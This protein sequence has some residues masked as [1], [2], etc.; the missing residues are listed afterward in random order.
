MVMPKRPVRVINP[1]AK[2]IAA[3]I[4]REVRARCGANATFEQRQD[5]AAMVTQE[6]P[7]RGK[8][9]LREALAEKDVQ[10][11]QTNV[12]VREREVAQM[13]R[14]AYAELFVARKAIDIH[15][16]SAG[17]LRQIAEHEGVT[18]GAA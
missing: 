5:V 9:Q 3:L 4:A 11:A 1:A 13:V 16:A 14:E 18:S 12:T 7:S 6:V 10:L 17:I 8:R 2:E 15:L